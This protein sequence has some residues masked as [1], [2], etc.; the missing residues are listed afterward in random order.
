MKEYL[1][2]KKLKELVQKYSEFI[3]F[4]IYIWSKKEVSKEVEIEEG[5]EVPKEEEKKE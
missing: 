1:E 4:P 3:N 5:E 2:E